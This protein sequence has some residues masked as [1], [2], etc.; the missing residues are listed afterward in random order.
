MSTLFWFPLRMLSINYINIK[1]FTSIN[2]VYRCYYYESH[3]LLMIDKEK[4]F[5]LLDC[6]QV[7]ILRFREK[8]YNSKFMSLQ[9]H[10]WEVKNTLGHKASIFD[11]FLLTNDSDFFDISASI[12]QY[13]DYYI[14]SFTLFSKYSDIVIWWENC[15]MKGK[16]IS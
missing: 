13:H 2:C 10:V 3:F 4:I 16:T 1:N 7:N 8:N 14:A 12:N 11:K 15:N 5:Q 9:P 6:S